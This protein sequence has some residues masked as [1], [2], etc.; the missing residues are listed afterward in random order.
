MNCVR[1]RVCV[2]GPSGIYTFASALVA[3]RVADERSWRRLLLL[4]LFR[5][6]FIYLSGGRRMCRVHFCS[7]GASRLS[8]V[9]RAPREENEEKRRKTKKN[10][11]SFTPHGKNWASSNEIPPIKVAN[12]TKR[13]QQYFSLLP[14]DQLLLL[15]LLWLCTLSLLDVVS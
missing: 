6:F 11:D 9:R 15:L 14:E 5:F 12:V 13:L 3:T 4:F 10:V 7:C 8:T 2:V 1:V